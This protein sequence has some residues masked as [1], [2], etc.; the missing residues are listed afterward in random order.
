MRAAILNDMLTLDAPVPERQRTASEFISENVRKDPKTRDAA[1]AET[2]LQGHVPD[3][4]RTFVP[5]TI[6]FK[7]KLGLSHRLELNVLYD[8]LMIGVDEDQLHAP[9]SPLKA[10]LV[11]DAWSCVLPTTK[12]V[13][14]IWQNARIKVAPQPWGPPYDATMMSMQRISAHDERVDKSILSKGFDASTALEAVLIAGHKKDVVITNQL[15]ARPKQ[16]AIFGWHQTNGKPIQP[17]YLGHENTYYDYS[18][19]VR[20]ISKRCTLD[21]IEDDLTRIMQDPVLHVAVSNEGQMKL[22]RQPLI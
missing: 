20:L 21:G 14:L 1:T 18:H 10:Q 16:V 11:A 12:L 2:L 6:D 4:L 3:L 15:A 13:D 9:M 22:T 19:S 17:L 7:D 5:L 8:Y